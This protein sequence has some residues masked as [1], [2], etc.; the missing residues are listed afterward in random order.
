MISMVHRKMDANDSQKLVG[1]YL[2]IDFN[3]D[4][5]VDNVND[6]A[7]PNGHPGNNAREYLYNATIGFEW[8]GFNCFAQ[9]YGVTNVTRDDDDQLCRR[10]GCPTCTTRVPG[11]A[12]TISMPTHRDSARFLR[13]LYQS[14]Y[15]TQYL[16]DGSFIRLK[17]VRGG[18]YLQ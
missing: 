9:A 18:L 17:N 3:G 2:I 14:Y 7:V 15:G 10:D 13:L 5:K 11:G 4:G 12:P 1:D 6:F 8:K 16:C